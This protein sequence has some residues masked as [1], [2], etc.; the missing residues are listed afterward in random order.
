MAG[1]EHV[2]VD[3]ATAQARSVPVRSHKKSVSNDIR[4]VFDLIMVA[5]PQMN[6]LVTSTQGSLLHIG[7]LNIYQ[8]ES[9]QD[10]VLELFQLLQVVEFIHRGIPAQ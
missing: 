5:V 8:Q 4:I 2:G 9:C 1:S 7:T 3:G 10:L 6:A